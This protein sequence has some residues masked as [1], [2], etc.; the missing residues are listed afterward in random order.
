LQLLKRNRL[1]HWNP[2]LCGLAALR[3]AP[4][5]AGVN[6]TG[7]RFRG[8]T[9]VAITVP[10]RRPPF[11]DRAGFADPTS[12]PLAQGMPHAAMLQHLS[13]P[14][15]RRYGSY[16]ETGRHGDPDEDRLRADGGRQRGDARGDR[17]VA[18]APRLRRDDGGGRRGG[19]HDAAAPV[20][21]RR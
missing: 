3:W 17:A 18:G 1:V 4:A 21:R 11:R 2:Q 15:R 16:G 7:T 19:A 5:A 12:V 9:V 13:R 20:I 10:P 8:L 6:P 14:R